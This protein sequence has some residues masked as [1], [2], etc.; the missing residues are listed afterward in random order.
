[1]AT[2]QDFKDLFA[3]LSAQGSE[4]I[5]VGAHAVMVHTE[6]RYT[7][8]LDVWIRPTPDNAER[9]YAALRDFGAPL[10]G[11]TIDDL[12]TPGVVFQIGVEPNR[13][14]ILTAIDGVTFDEAWS[15]RVPSTYGGVPIALLA[16]EDLIRNKRAAGRPQD[17]LDVAKLEASLQSRG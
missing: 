11:L 10:V 2:N 8:D 13:I 4:F 6:P 16:M 3:A 7:K 1:M 14:D 17:L 15:R 9:V 12:S 5:V